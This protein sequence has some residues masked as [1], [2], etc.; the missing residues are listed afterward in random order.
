MDREGKGEHSRIQS[1]LEAA[2]DGDTVLVSPGTYEEN[3]SFLGKS[4]ELRSAAR[5]EITIIDGGGLESTVRF[6]AGEGRKTALSG[7][8]VRNGH[9]SVGGGV[10]VFNA[11]PAITGCVITENRAG[12]GIGIGV[13]FGSPLIQGNTITGN[14][15]STR[16][17]GG[18]GGGGIY[19]GSTPGAEVVSN[20]IAD[21]TIGSGAG[22]GGIFLNNAGG[23]VISRNLIHGNT[24]MLAVPPDSP[25]DGGGI[26]IV[27]TLNVFVEQN[28][29]LSNRADRGSGV[30]WI[31][32][33]GQPGP[34]LINNTLAR[35]S[36]KEGA[37]VFANGF[38]AG[39]RLVNKILLGDPGTPA[40]SCGDTSPGTFPRFLFNDIWSGGGARFGGACADLEPG[41]GNISTDPS[42]VDPAGEDYRLGPDSP[43]REAGTLA[44]APET[45][46]DGR[47][48]P[49]GA[50]VDLGVYELCE[51]ITGFLRGDANVDGRRDISDAILVLRRLFSSG[52][53]PPCLKAADTDDNGVISPSDPVS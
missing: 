52:K 53:A 44:G 48:R 23:S 13:E 49:C 21:N 27:N 6:I 19:L 38:D 41:G 15:P 2:Q 31:A 10:R 45:D 35:N 29:V 18:L 9:A 5:P 25:S 14:R 28:L 46:W 50:G 34:T 11:S 3:V 32:G 17:F 40:V 22:G 24:A 30:W 20:V 16:F 42:F 33:D 8:T 37:A 7:F 36:A 47:P 43:C 12:G 4:V 39:A 51:E 26:N 1:V